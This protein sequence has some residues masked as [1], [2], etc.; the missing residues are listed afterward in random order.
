MPRGRPKFEVTPELT[1]KAEALAAQGLTLEQIASVLGI[2]YQTLNERR[3][4][5]TDFAEAIKRGKNKGIAQVSNK[6]FQ[7]AME[8][9][10]KRRITGEDGKGIVIKW[11]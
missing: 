7:K 3:K 6:L 9:V 1:K 4:E 2:S 8:D 10:Q 11:K 5:Y